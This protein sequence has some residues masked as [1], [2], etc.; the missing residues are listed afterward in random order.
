LTLAS[1]SVPRPGPSHAGVVR[2]RRQPLSAAEHRRLRLRRRSRRELIAWAFLAP[3]FVFFVAFLV[4]PVIGVFWWSTQKGGV[5][6]GTEFVGINNFLRLPNQIDAPAAISNTFS[7]AL[8]SIP[9]TLILALF[10]ALLLARVRRGG[11]TYRFLVYFPV[12]VPGVVAG[13]IWI[14]LVNIDFG[15]FNTVLKLVGLQPQVWLGA[16]SALGV[17]AALDVWRSVGYWAIFFLAAIIGLPLELYQAAELDG[18]GSWQRFRHLTLP[19]LRRVIL[20]AIVVATI[21]G[22]QVFDTALILTSGGPG[23]STITIVFRIW[24]YVFGESNK[25]GYGAA[26]SVALLVAILVLTLIQLRVLRGRRG[27]V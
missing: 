12:L 20:F 27:D 17:L 5:T 1:D 15:L 14:F 10:T 11:S 9:P 18:A 3:M 2:P 16:G 4:I 7:F 25:A 13:L 8:M 19:L 26:I 23:T 22:L 24:K 6:T 21:F